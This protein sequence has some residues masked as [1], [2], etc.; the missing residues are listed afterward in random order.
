MS[1]SIISSSAAASWAAPAA[2][3]LAF[4]IES[5]ARQAT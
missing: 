2:G 5:K 4:V 1:A 3:W